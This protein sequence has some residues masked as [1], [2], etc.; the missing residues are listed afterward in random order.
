METT[1]LVEFGLN[2]VLF[3]A[4]Y[5][6]FSFRILLS[7][8]SGTTRES[9]RARPSTA[10]RAI[11]RTRRHGGGKTAGQLDVREMNNIPRVVRHQAMRLSIGGGPSM[12]AAV[13]AHD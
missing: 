7:V 6:E 12:H 2:G 1:R 13:P 9:L 5:T 11:T 3:G 8:E 10:G 4:D